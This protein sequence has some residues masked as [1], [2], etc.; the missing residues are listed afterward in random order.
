MQWTW[1]TVSV[2][3]GGETVQFEGPGRAAGFENR[4][5][6]WA[7]AARSTSSTVGMET[8]ATAYLKDLET[9]GETNPMVNVS[10]K[11]RV[12][13]KENVKLKAV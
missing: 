9:A 5:G 1:A 12:D 10:Q 2:V 8:R 11:E 4:D 3:V 6:N 7:R 13:V